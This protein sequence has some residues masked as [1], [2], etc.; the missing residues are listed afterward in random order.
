M[1][2]LLINDYLVDFGGAEKA[3]FESKS[4]L[5]EAGFNVA[6]IGGNKNFSSY[7]SRW[8]SIRYFFQTLLKIYQFKPNI[9]H[10]HNIS[11]CVS[12][13]PLVAAKLM[14][15]PVVMTFHDYHLVYPKTVPI[16]TSTALRK[17]NI[18]NLRLSITGKISDTIKYL[19]T[20]LHRFI[21]RRTVDL[22]ISPSLDLKILIEKHLKLKT[23]YLPN[24]YNAPTYILPSVK[25][26]KYFLFV[27]RLTAEK[28][29]SALI[30][31]FAKLP[32]E[33][34]TIIGS[35][36]QKEMLEKKVE[37]LDLSQR[38]LFLGNIE[39]SNLNKYYHEAYSLII[40]S[41]CQENNPIVA[42]E[43]LANGTP[44]IVSNRGGLPDF[45]KNDAV[46]LV[47]NSEL[48]LTKSLEI[49]KSN[50]ARVSLPTIYS[51][52]HYLRVLIALYNHFSRNG[53]V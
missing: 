18:Y 12:P 48:Q 4:V 10:C 27:G 46:C 6:V 25:S 15:V 24:F 40:P 53:V 21:I 38:I 36:P 13:S 39:N 34:L 41:I 5:Q 47:Y 1:N 3:F 19:K 11:R 8:F 52:Q 32:N 20:S 51:K 33:K 9:V 14:G 7:F 50:K 37:D 45:S 43:S 26:P 23:V 22:A 44:I 29:V 2:I 16:D 42:L 17:M 31:T 35:G 49:I 28:G 30:E